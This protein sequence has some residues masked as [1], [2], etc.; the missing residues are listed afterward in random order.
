MT[1]EGG[2]FIHLTCK[3]WPFYRKKF[4]KSFLTANRLQRS[5][6]LIAEVLKHE[7]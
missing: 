3:L 1:R 7:I 4:K 6:L 2:K 5:Q